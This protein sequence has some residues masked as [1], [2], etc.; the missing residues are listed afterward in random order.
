MHLREHQYKS[1]E[2]GKVT[3]KSNGGEALS[4]EFLFKSNG[5]EALNYVF[6][7]KVRAMKH[8]MKRK[9]CSNKAMKRLKL[10]SYLQIEAMKRLTLHRLAS[11]LH[12]C[13]HYINPCR[14]R[15]KT[16]QNT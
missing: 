7:Q 2:V 16:R 10:L 9:N 8:L 5:N 1:A 6:P 15:H 3:L 4:V 14:N 13:Q 12:R 11:S